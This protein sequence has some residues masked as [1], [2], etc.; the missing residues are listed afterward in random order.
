MKALWLAEAET[1]PL[2]AERCHGGGR[3]K[4][5]INYVVQVQWTVFIA[6]QDVCARHMFLYRAL[7]DLNKA[8]YW[9]TIVVPMDSVIVHRWW[10]GWLIRVCDTGSSLFCRVRYAFRNHDAWINCTRRY[11]IGLVSDRHWTLPTVDRFFLPFILL[12][13]D[14]V[15]LLF[16]Y[17]VFVQFVALCQRS[18]CA[19]GW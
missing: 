1:S 19:Y 11:G 6:A 5:L 15:V 7:H 16:F 13:Y 10:R 2:Q 3:H 9:C 12:C 4:S 17:V 18:V 14:C 8:L